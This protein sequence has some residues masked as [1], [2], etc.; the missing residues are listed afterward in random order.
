[1]GYGTKMNLIFQI[2]KKNSKNEMKDVTFLIQTRLDSLDRL[3]N[4]KTTV[5]FIQK[6][7]DT[8]IHILEADRFKSQL[9][10]KVVPA[11]VI[12]AFVNDSDNKKNQKCIA[13]KY[14]IGFIL[15]HM[16]C[17]VLLN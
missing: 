4:L 14:L 1:M 9:I 17:I 6:H 2:Q 13:L 12:V 11:E 16:L 10:S 7:F 8:N 15:F 5:D 3:V